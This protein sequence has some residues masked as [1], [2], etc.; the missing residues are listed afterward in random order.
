MVNPYYVKTTSSFSVTITTSS[1]AA[2][3]TITSGL[4]FTPSVGAITLSSSSAAS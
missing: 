1:N 3:A 2:I 4:T